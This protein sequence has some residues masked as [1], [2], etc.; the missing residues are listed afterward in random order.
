MARQNVGNPKFYIDMLSYFK[1]QGSFHSDTTHPNILGGLNPAQ[2]DIVNI[3]TIDQSTTYDFTVRLDVNNRFSGTDKHFLAFLNHNFYHE[4]IFKPKL[5][6]EIYDGDTSSWAEVILEEAF[7]EIC[8]FSITNDSGSSPFAYNGWSLGEYT[9]GNDSFSKAHF[10]ISKDSS[11]PSTADVLLGSIAWGQVFQMPHSPDLQLTVTREYDGIKTQQTKGGSTLTQIDYTGS[12][13]WGSRNP[14]Y[15]GAHD[16]LNEINEGKTEKRQYGRGR[17]IWDLKFSYI[18]SDNLFPV[19]ESISRYN[20]T[21]SAYLSDYSDY[22]NSSYNFNTDAFDSSSFMSV[23]MGKTLGGALPF[24][25]Q[26]DG[27]NNSPDQFAICQID[28]GSFQ[29]KQVAH[30]VYDIS[31]K[32]KEV[33]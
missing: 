25:F 9:A 10:S 4:S 2:Y 17:K 15:V 11:I 12:A 33:W 6:T 28:Q 8:N 29:F 5:K 23:V 26:P 20:P 14:W 24:I 30:N 16:L 7:D 22:I 19:N 13:L 3:D 21:D 31:L 18:S 27:N 1:A 32:I